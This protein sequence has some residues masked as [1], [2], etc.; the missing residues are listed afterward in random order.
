MMV[1]SDPPVEMSYSPA[2][3]TFSGSLSVAALLPPG[4]EIPIQVGVGA[5]GW[6]VGGA[7]TSVV[8]NK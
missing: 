6:F 3:N 1:G 7:V 2:T 5:E 8:V 4:L